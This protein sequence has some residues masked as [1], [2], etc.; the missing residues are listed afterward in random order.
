MRHMG[1][2]KRKEKPPWQISVTFY[3]VEVIKSQIMT[4]LD[5]QHTYLTRSPNKIDVSPTC[6]T[7]QTCPTAS[8]DLPL[9]HQP[10]LT[11]CRTLLQCQQLPS[12]PNGRKK[13]TP[14]TQVSQDMAV[15]CEQRRWRSPSN[16]R[17]DGPEDNT[18]QAMPVTKGTVPTQQTETN[19]WCVERLL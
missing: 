13:K 7:Y 9:L 3:N 14:Q 15:Q 16:I 18:G 11:E 2:A 6:L 4:D 10:D 19:G 5:W 8:R 12:N 1:L 17:C